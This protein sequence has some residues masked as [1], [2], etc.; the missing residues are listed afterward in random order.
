MGWSCSNNQT[1]PPN[2]FPHPLTCGTCL[3]VTLPP[4]FPFLRIL[5]VL[6]ERER[7][8]WGDRERTGGGNRA[9]VQRQR[10]WTVASG[11]ATEGEGE[12]LAARWTESSRTTKG[13]TSRATVARHGRE[14]E[15]ER[16]GREGGSWAELRRT[17]GDWRWRWRQAA[18][19]ARTVEKKPCSVE[20]GE[21]ARHD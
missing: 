7:G 11:H 12:S 1:R 15:R 16:E 14:G 21:G 10:G 3:A 8:E 20:T 6:R 5:P 18:T 17:R 2:I 13:A 4:S 19:Y 9:A